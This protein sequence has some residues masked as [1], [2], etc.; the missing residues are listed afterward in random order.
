[1]FERPTNFR[2]PMVATA[3]PCLRQTDVVIHQLGNV[4]HDAVI[5]CNEIVVRVPQLWQVET[6]LGWLVSGDMRK[7]YTLEIQWE[8]LMTS[9]FGICTR[10]QVS[11][12]GVA[13][14]I[15]GDYGF[16]VLPA[17]HFGWLT[18][19]WLIAVG[20]FKDK[21][22]QNRGCQDWTSED[23]GVLTWSFDVI[24]VCLSL[25]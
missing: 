6:A 9:A 25:I 21:K 13:C 19:F 20:S 22:C 5:L 8:R 1:M 4:W 2:G 7:A 12:K 23:V 16:Y 24:C 11:L 18:P 3:R 17:A 10:G 15:C 14:W